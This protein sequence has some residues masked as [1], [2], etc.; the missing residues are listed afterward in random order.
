MSYTE[1]QFFPKAILSV[2]RKEIDHLQLNVKRACGIKDTTLPPDLEGHF[3]LTAPAGTLDSYRPDPEKNE[4]IALPAA[5]GLTPLFNGDG[6]V[7]R[8]DFVEGKATVK[9]RI[10]KPPC[11]YAD[12]LTQTEEQ[13]QDLKFKN[14]GYGRLSFVKDTFVSLGIRNQLNTAFVPFKFSTNDQER[15]L[16]TWDTGRHFEIDPDTLELVAPIGWNDEW[17][18]TTSLTGNLPFSQVMS[19]SHPCFDP[20]GGE[21]QNGEFFTVNVSKSISTILWLSRSLKLRLEKLLESVKA[22]PLKRRLRAIAVS[23]NIFLA[24][25][26]IF[27]FFINLFFGKGDA[28]YLLRWDGKPFAS[29]KTKTLDQWKV[30]NSKGYPI[31]IHQTLHQM[32]LT[33]DFVILTDTA[34]KFDL[35][36]VIPFLHDDIANQVLLLIMYLFDYAAYPETNLYI[37]RRADLV[38]SKKRVKAQHFKLE[39]PMTHYIVDYEN[40]DGKI[41]LHAAHICATD[42]SETLRISDLSIYKDLGITRSLRQ[43][44]GSIC[45]PTD[46]NRVGCYVIDV[47]N[48][49]VIPYTKYDVEKTWATAFYACR[50][51]QHSAR[52]DDIY[53]NSW[54]C[55]T[56]TLSQHILSLYKDYEDRQIPVKNSDD[57]VDG[58]VE[59]PLS[60][61][62]RSTDKTLFEIAL[63]GI[64]SN[65]CRVHIE[66]DVEGLPVGIQ[67]MDSYQFPKGYLGT[68]AQF[69]PKANS[70]G[71][72]Q[73]YIVCVVIT[74][75]DC[76]CPLDEQPRQNNSEIWIFDAEKDNLGGEPLCRLS[77]PQ[78]H[79]GFTLH[80][81]WLPPR[82]PSP[83]PTPTTYDVRQDYDP[84]VQTWLDHQ[85]QKQCISVETR[86]KIE[87]LFEAVYQK[88]EQA[89][90][91]R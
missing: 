62:S 37:V 45:G 63:K 91:N 86:E 59:Q 42:P 6:M 28:V 20:Q 16:I 61:I 22:S 9:T 85:I 18:A 46:V 82:S 87:N 66:R 65:L 13:F 43:L 11:Y 32:A 2:S 36:E 17:N 31:K 41:V 74:P 35:S 55:W 88:W 78:L 1:Y 76:D 26:D 51:E 3:F 12:E 52:F 24:I 21:K 69:I 75:S 50:N 81:T 15:L 49:K 27:H 89:H 90:Q 40:P 7:Y 60:E 67:L 5:D 71:S 79:L 38:P 84:Q 83:S 8:V 4:H 34:F 73:G 72:R 53:W 30:V 14:F 57:L 68:S 29:E 58:G 64:P 77:H 23:L 25:D 47:D 80:T 39:Y 44:A 19:T 70:T 10:V 48:Q 54:G 33:R 56:D